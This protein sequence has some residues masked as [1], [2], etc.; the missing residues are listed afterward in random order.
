MFLN[1]YLSFDIYVD[2]SGPNCCRLFLV[3]VLQTFVV[4][5]R[6]MT[7]APPPHSL[8]IDPNVVVLF[9]LCSLNLHCARY[10]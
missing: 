7:G 1:Y 9:I 6:K 4:I 5:L 2:A 10:V 8:Q 3:Y